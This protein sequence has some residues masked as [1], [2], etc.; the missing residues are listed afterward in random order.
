M[1]STVVKKKA[2]L[3]LVG[4]SCTSCAI[5]IEHVGRRI[6]GITDIFVDRGT[7]T[8]QIEYDGNRESLERICDVVDR[9]GYEATIRATE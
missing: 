5:T 7:S 8:I 4:A 3:D 9:I 6:E 2:V 1:E